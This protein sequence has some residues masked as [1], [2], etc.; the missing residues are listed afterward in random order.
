MHIKHNNK[1]IFLNFLSLYFFT[2]NIV[3]NSTIFSTKNNSSK[4]CTKDSIK[5]IQFFIE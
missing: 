3:Q 2:N 4:L 1:I 5:C